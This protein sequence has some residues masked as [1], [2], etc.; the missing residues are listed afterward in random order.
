VRIE[1]PVVIFKN[2]YDRSDSVADRATE[3]H[4]MI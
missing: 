4:M 3:G 1:A 2:I